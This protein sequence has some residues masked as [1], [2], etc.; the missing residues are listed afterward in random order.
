MLSAL[1]AT[2]DVDEIL[3]NTGSSEIAEA[4][5]GFDA[6]VVERPEEGDC[7]SLF[8]VTPLRTRPWE[9][10]CTP[11][12]HD[13]DELKRT[14]DLDPVYEGN[15]DVYRFAPESLERGGNRIGDDPTMFPIDAM[16]AIDIDEMVD[17]RIAEML[18]RDRNGEDPPLEEVV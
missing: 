4:A 12:N 2:P 10:D 14:Q 6:M 7:D 1:T 11:I 8:S 3:V 15:S 18:H 16:W 17:F 13:R 9:A 5:R